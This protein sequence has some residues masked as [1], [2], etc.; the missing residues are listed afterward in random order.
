MKFDYIQWAILLAVFVPTVIMDIKELK[1]CLWPVFC[2]IAAGILNTVFT[3]MPTISEYLLRFLPG[4][5]I[6]T[7]AYLTKG[8]MGKGDGL[9]LLFLGSVVE[10]KYVF[11]A[12]LAGF[13]LA[14][15]YGLV[16]MALKK[17]T[18]KTKLPFIPFLF[19]GVSIC[20]FL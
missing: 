11:S 5:A 16:K 10:L 4:I 15:L 12:M 6:L 13:I 18:G 3:G 2:G 7:W 8:C 20:G 14:A 1:I 9:M 17:A 19:A